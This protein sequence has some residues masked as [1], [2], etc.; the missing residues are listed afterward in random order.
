MSEE[1]RRDG[2]RFI[3]E[4]S[5]VLFP[6]AGGA[7]L[8]DRA[9]AHDVSPKGFKVETQAPLTQ[10]MLISFSL[11]LPL[12][13]R[14]GGKGRV[15]WSNRESFAT[16]AGVEIVS[17]PWGDRRRLGAYLNPEQTDWSRLMGLGVKL[18]MALTVV[19]AAHR[20]FYS[21]HLRELLVQLAPKA[22]A[23]LVMGW[24]LLGLLKRERR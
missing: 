11:E 4:L 18:V 22:F 7:A 17:I 2:T 10:G 20:I 16:W 8:D 13:L 19:V 24:A 5:A 9:T 12:G 1:D 14:V 15:V 3:T 21:A 6:S 23:L